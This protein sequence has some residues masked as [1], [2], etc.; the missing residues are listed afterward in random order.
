MIDHG[1]APVRHGALADTL[2]RVN[3]L[4]RLRRDELTAAYG[5]DA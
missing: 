5:H 4:V 3:S 2:Q 1:S